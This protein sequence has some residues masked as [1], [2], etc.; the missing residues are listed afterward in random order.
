MLAIMAAAHGGQVLGSAVTA[1]LAS[2]QLPDRLSLRDLGVHRLRD[3]SESEHIFQLVHSELPDAFGPLR[4]LDSYRSN[5]PIQPTAFVGREAGVREIAKALE[6]ARLVTLCG[7]GGV[8][9]TRLALQGAA[10]VL[11]QLEDGLGRRAR[12]RR[13]G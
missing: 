2:H 11:P 8:G 1:T 12:K 3:L 13:S 5:L 9:K 10:E 6:D 7:V 4:S